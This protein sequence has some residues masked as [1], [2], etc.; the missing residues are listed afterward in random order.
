MFLEPG[1]QETAFE[2]LWIATFPVVLFFLKYVLIFK[3]HKS[4]KNLAWNMILLL[5][6]I[7]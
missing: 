7:V 1:Y 6:Q 4:T 2:L 3:E 5:N